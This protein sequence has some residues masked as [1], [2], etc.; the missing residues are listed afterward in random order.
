MLTGFQTLTQNQYR[1]IE[2]LQAK[3][4]KKKD[5]QFYFL[6]SSLVSLRK[7]TGYVVTENRETNQKAREELE[8]E[9]EIVE[10]NLK[11]MEEKTHKMIQ[12]LESKVLAELQ[13]GWEGMS[14]F[15][16]SEKVFSMSTPVSAT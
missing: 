8:F 14:K 2:A 12:E 10:Q 6:E 15:L 1:F 5:D 9:L 7:T 13:F 4:K 11:D 3:K 16:Q